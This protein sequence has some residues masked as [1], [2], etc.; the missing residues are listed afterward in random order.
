MAEP[1]RAAAFTRLAAHAGP[2]PL[3]IAECRAR[4]LITIGGP[5]ANPGFVSAVRAAVGAELPRE[6]GGVVA[7]GHGWTIWLGP[8]EWLYVAPGR[9]GWTLERDLVRALGP[10]GGQAVDVGHGRAVLRLA[11]APVRAVLAKGCPVDVSSGALPAGRAVQSLFGKIG[12]LLHARER[13]AVELY[14]ARSYADALAD[15]VLAAAREFGCVIAP[16]ALD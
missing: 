1:A 8:A 13:D 9:D 15:A 4:A 5:V 11:G 12:V 16:A 10:V 14:V 2:D 6:P 7:A 3:A